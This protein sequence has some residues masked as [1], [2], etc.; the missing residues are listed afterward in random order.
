LEFVERDEH[1]P[2]PDETPELLGQMTDLLRNVTD[3]LVVIKRDAADMKKKMT[4]LYIGW[5]RHHERL[6][7]IGSKLFG[8]LEKENPDWTQ[9]EKEAAWKHIAAERDDKPAVPLFFDT[10]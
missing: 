1:E 10:P 4:D 2:E 6:A 9:A 7:S 3:S 8:L 5:Y